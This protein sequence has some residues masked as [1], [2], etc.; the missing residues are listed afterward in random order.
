LRAKFTDC[1]KQSKI[2]D[3]KADQAFAAIQQL[4]ALQD[5]NSLVDLL[6]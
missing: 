1:A 5:V 2:G 4:E 3:A 6:R